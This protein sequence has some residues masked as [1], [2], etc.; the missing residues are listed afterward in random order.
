MHRVHLHTRGGDGDVVLVVAV[1]GKARLRAV[2]AKALP[3]DRHNRVLTDQHAIEVPLDWSVDVCSKVYPA[4]FF[5]VQDH[6]KQQEEV[7]AST[8]V[9][10]ELHNVHALLLP[11]Y[12]SFVK[13][14]LDGHGEYRGGLGTLVKMDKNWLLNTTTGAP[15]RFPP[16]APVKRDGLTLAVAGGDGRNVLLVDEMH[17]GFRMYAPKQAAEAMHPP[18]SRTR[19]PP[20]LGDDKFGAKG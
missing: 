12:R 18:F 1:E 6:I 13:W 2:V 11:E 19:T 16:L 20:L 5:T 3:E 10:V 7:H 17:P 15:V 4:L 8:P 14:Y 9:V